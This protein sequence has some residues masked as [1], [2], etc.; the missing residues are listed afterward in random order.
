MVG[1]PVGVFVFSLIAVKLGLAELPNGATLRHLL[2]V[3]LLAGVG[4][5]MALFIGGLAFDD[6][7]LVDV[8]KVGILAGSVIAAF[9]GIAV[10]GIGSKPTTS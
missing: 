10:L 8:S 7:A 1:K 5:T 3:G 6:A 2:G 4:F 9:L